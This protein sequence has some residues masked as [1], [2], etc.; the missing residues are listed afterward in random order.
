MCHQKHGGTA[1]RYTDSQR[2]HGKAIDVHRQPKVFGY[3]T[4]SSNFAPLSM[5]S[6]C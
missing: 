5:L 2:K 3:L 4:K 6:R 1:F